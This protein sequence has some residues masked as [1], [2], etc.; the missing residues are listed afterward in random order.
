MDMKK[1]VT[2][3]EEGQISKRSCW[4]LMR[5]KFLL[6]QECQELIAETPENISIHI[7]KNGVIYESEGGAKLFFDFEEQPVSRAE[8]MLCRSEREDWDFIESLIPANGT[9]LDI[10]A[11]VGWFTIQL[12]K[13]YPESKIYAFEPV[14]STYT[15]M[16]RNLSLNGIVE[17]SSRGGQVFAVNAGLYDKDG[18]STIYV[19]GSSE[20]S[21]LQPIND[22]FYLRKDQEGQAVQTCQ[23]KTMDTFVREQGIDCLDFIKCD[24]EGAE[25]MVFAGARHVLGELRP[26]V[27]TEM[28]RK[29]AKRFGYHP[30]EIIELFREF[31]YRCYREEKSRLIPFE[32]M[33]ENTAETNFFFMH[34]DKHADII[35]KYTEE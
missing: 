5:E 34:V 22:A 26:M 14:A 33:D 13:K 11:N 35:R 6:L 21:S 25:K 23:I 30:N 1:I 20:A 24:T 28:L 9:V 32:A 2:L 17:L 29:H 3:A 4:Q 31:G 19:P 16:R 7:E 27:Y 10:G 12:A 18:A 15:R 8:A